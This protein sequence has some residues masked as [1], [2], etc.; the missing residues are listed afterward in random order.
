MAKHAVSRRNFMGGMA[1]A[2]GYLSTR[3]TAAI[4]PMKLRRDTACLAIR[5]LEAR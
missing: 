5:P 2:V 3:P 1:A 4:P